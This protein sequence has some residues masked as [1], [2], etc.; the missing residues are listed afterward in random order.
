MR[1]LFLQG[2]GAFGKLGGNRDI[3]I[4]FGKREKLENVVAIS[5][6]FVPQ[7]NYIFKRFYFFEDNLGFFIVVPEALLRGYLFAFGNGCAFLIDVKDTSVGYR[8]DRSAR[9][10]CSFLAFRPLQISL[11]LMYG[12]R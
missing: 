12:R 11:M 8:R 9:R 3:A 2:H 5:F 6:C 7:S 1:N 10:G 4:L